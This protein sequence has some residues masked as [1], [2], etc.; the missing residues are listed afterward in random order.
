MREFGTD[1]KEYF[2]S[3]YYEPADQVLD[4]LN[5]LN[6]EIDKLPDKK[7][8]SLE[9]ALDRAPEYV[10][11]TGFCLK[12]LR[13]E[14]FDVPLAAARMALYFQEKEALFGEDK[15]CRDILLSD[16]NSDDLECLK[17]GYVQVC[18]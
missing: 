17:T 13:A 12:F 6:D 15:L 5:D 3:S 16:L 9:K 10:L 8:I 14:Q 7:K 2:T 11:D 1:G 4:A 18:R